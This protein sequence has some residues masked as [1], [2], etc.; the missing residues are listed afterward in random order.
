MKN[1]VTI[2]DCLS[3]VFELADFPMKKEDSKVLNSLYK[4]MHR[5]MGL[6]DR[7]H[8]LLKTILSKYTEDF[9]KYNIVLEEVQDILKYPLRKIDRSHWIKVLDYKQKKML[10]I[11]FPY[12]NKIIDRISE[13]RKITDES[14]YE[15][16]VHYFLYNERN[17]WEVMQIANRFESKFEVEENLLDLFNKLKSIYDNKENYIPGVYDNEVRN[18]SEHAS[19]ALDEHL[20][21]SKDL[22]LLYDRRYVFGLEHFD[23]ELID[24]ELTNTDVL[25]AKLVKR[26]DNFV[27]IKPNEYSFNN[28]ISSIFRLERLPLLVIIHTNNQLDQ[29]RTVHRIFRC[30]LYV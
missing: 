7:Q 26:N 13:L 14:Y 8:V 17:A 16:K 24:R 20:N 21:N 22:L 25:T 3:L 6:T 12:N 4:Q 5:K 9:E 18:L 29:L 10:A 30:T 23:Q 28:V 15:D 27:S 11:R 1:E 2:E 19:E